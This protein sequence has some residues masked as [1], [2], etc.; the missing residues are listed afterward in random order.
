[1]FSYWGHSENPS[2]LVEAFVDTAH[3]LVDAVEPPKLGTNLRA[4]KSSS[5]ALK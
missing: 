1:M 2:R 5:P 3:F 4:L